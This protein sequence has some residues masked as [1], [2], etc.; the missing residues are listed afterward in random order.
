MAFEEVKDNITELKENTK[1]YIDSSINYYSLLGFKIT[2][3][4]AILLFKNIIFSLFL[5]LSLFLLSFAAAFAFGQY[6]QS[7]AIGF[8][9]V[10]GVYLI[11]G[12]VFW[13]VGTKLLEKPLIKVMSDIF[14]KD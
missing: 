8:V 2:T 10:G 11:I 4:A 7:Y 12:I 14:F 6:Y 13:F 5:L 3:K 9:I 1:Q